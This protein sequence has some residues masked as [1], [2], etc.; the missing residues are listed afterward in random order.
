MASEAR[1]DIPKA[2]DPTGVEDR[3]YATWMERGYFGASAG[4]GREPFC[5]VLPPPNITGALHIGHA[6]DH[7][8]PDV[9]IRR[10]RMQGYEAL[11]LPGTDHAGIATEV[12]V[13]RQLREEGTSP[14]ELGREAFIERV[15]R[16][17]EQYG[18]TIVEQMKRL[19]NSCDWSR[20]RF[21]MDDGLVRAV[22]VAFV[23]LYE[24]GLIY[25]GER[26]INWCPTDHTAL[27]DSEVEHH[28]VAGEL[29]TFRYEIS[30]GSGHVDVA[31]TRVETMLG[32][33]GVAVHPDDERYRGVVGKA[34]RHPFTGEDLPIVADE[35]VDPAFGTGAVKVTPAHDP[36]DFDIAERAGVPAR[37][38]LTPDATISDQAPEQ[39][40]GLDRYEA[41]SRVLEA[42]RERGLV[43]AEERPYHHPV[44]HCYRCG[45]E[46]EPWLS[47]KQWFVA[48][49]RL[50]ASAREAASDGRIR[51]FPERWLGPFTAWL[52]D[53]RDWNISRQ[54]WWGHRIPV[55][56]CPNGHEFAAV[57]DPAACPECRSED[58]EQ[59]P[60][61]LDTW[62]S[63]QL[64]PFSTL[65][66]P[67]E[68]PDLD[69]FYPTSVLVTGYEILYL[70][71]A[72]MV[73][74][75]L[76]LMGDV[77]FSRVLI[78]GLV[79]DEQNR[80]MSKSLGNVIDPLDMIDRHGADALRFAL[81]RMAGP[82]QQNIPFGERDVEAARHFAN[83][84]WN[85]ARLVLSA[86]PDDPGVALVDLFAS[87]ADILTWYQ[88]RVANEA[89]L[90]SALT[91]RWILSRHEACR[92]EVDAALEEHRF[93]D[94]AQALQRFLWA[95][96][97][98]WGLEMAKPALY[99]RT[100]EQRA[101][102]RT[103]LAWVL[104]RTLRL[105]HPL[106]PFLTEEIWQRLGTG[107][108]IVVAPWPEQRPEH[109]D[110]RAEHR[111]G[112][113]ME[114]VTALRRFRSD[115]HV[116]PGVALTAR[117]HG[118][119]ED[120]AIVDELEEEIRRLARLDSLETVDGTPDPSGSARLIVGSSEVL[121]P[122]AGVLDP[123]AECA[124]LRGRLEELATTAERSGR[125][126]ANEG[127]LAKA[128]AHIVDGERRKLAS[129]KEERAALEAQL[130]ELGCGGGPGG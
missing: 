103:V 46:I 57:E 42:L 64:W 19:G 70:W 106:M 27:S 53:L 120:R 81:A 117:V 89:H 15:W 34:V 9:I 79:R 69:F 10:K 5:I 12:L 125:K 111:L 1:T 25:R 119:E 73:M 112:F 95:E 127:F 13:G 36:A 92:A 93:T 65:G 101:G 54:L 59:D 49:E 18:G 114:V 60:D 56:Y 87:Q 22:R 20:L 8:L 14:Q 39:F 11:W 108:S 68:N 99:D 61:V 130:A 75:G 38:I 4:S 31:T 71:V 37:N 63:S 102:M 121:V 47:G 77:P 90:G 118:G 115:H 113:A 83:K 28:E 78:H 17:K 85:A 7:T 128:P 48:V 100:A 80:K 30:D 26:I 72:R 76:Y 40:R 96:L 62:F 67:D 105:L 129:L 29:V 52:D 104:E 82:D 33:T 44:G 3:W 109:R 21:T 84:I 23:R 97:A 124:R 91:V 98:D 16:W 51:F 116:P 24:D 35:A 122:L 88:D 43:V 74:S 66:W 110:E 86:A 107:E 32:D 126:L 6:L 123:E 58:I 41:R 94:A 2:Y 50:K 55:W 45:S